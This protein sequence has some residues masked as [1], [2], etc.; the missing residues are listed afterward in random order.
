MPVPEAAT[1]SGSGCIPRRYKLPIDAVHHRVI[2]SSEHFSRSARPS[3]G[4]SS[5]PQEWRK[6]GI[7]DEMK[8]RI[9]S[10]LLA[11]SLV[12][13]AAALASPVA[14]SLGRHSDADSIRF[15]WSRTSG[16]NDYLDQTWWA[17]RSHD[18]AD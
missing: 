10:V 17:V 14:A 4:S 6:N 12:A 9:L 15:G 11:G 16:S 2:G 18:T 8:R 5:E 3:S 7:A 13:S 1:S